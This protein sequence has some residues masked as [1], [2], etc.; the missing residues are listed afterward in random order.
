MLPIITII[1][2]TQRGPRLVDYWRDEDGT[3]CLRVGRYFVEW[4]SR[5]PA[6]R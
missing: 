1:P 5:R 2:M 6:H 3:R 4:H